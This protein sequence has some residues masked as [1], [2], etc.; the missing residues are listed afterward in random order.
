VHCAKNRKKKLGFMNVLEIIKRA[1]KMLKDGLLTLIEDFL[2]SEVVEHK[3]RL[4]NSYLQNYKKM[5]V[6]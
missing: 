6:N 2:K 5:Y 4:Q 1:Y 3:L